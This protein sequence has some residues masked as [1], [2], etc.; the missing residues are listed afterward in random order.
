MYKLNKRV[1]II[2]RLDWKSW[3]THTWLTPRE[4]QTVNGPL[5]TCYKVKAPLKFVPISDEGVSSSGAAFWIQLVIETPQVRPLMLS[6]KK[7]LCWIWLQLFNS[8][9]VA[10]LHP[11][12]HCYNS[13]WIMGEVLDEATVRWLLRWFLCPVSRADERDKNVSLF[14]VIT[15]VF[16]ALLSSFCL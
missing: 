13:E 14:W 10:K 9:T 6:V 15:F 4:Q 1:I 5:L 12:L 2:S 16:T 7:G 11:P 3:L 8:R